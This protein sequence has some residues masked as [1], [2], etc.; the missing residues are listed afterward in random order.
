MIVHIEMHDRENHA[1]AIAEYYRL[2]KKV[3]HDHLAWDVP[4]EGDQEKDLLDDLPCTYALSLGP[5][6]AVDAG[7]RLI[8]TTQTTLLDLAFDGLV[9]DDFNF[10]SPTIWELSR[11]CVD[12][13]MATDRLPAGLGLA[14][15]QLT[16]A[17]VDYAR[18]NGITHYIAVT[19]ERIF[20]LTK[21]FELGMELL[22]RRVIDGCPVVCGLFSIDERALERAERMRPLAAG[23][24][25]ITRATPP[26]DTDAT[27]HGPTPEA[28]PAGRETTAPK[29]RSPPA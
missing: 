7:I 22:A 1:G 29:K 27:S 8:P 28:L 6:G 26:S 11:Y 21:L 3:F 14:S 4:V 9:P 12:H 15:L 23:A 17:N 2:R 10:R 16:I 20:E 18:R 24:S 19:E 5:D 25:A 13:D